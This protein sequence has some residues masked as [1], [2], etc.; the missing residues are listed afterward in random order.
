MD[1]SPHERDLSQ[2]T[3]CPKLCRFCCPTA[4]VE[5]KETVTPW[6]KMTLCEMFRLGRLRS[7][8]EIGEVFFHCFTCLHCRTHCRHGVDVPSALI[9]GRAGILESG[10]G[11]SEVS[12]V[13]AR[14]EASGNPWGEDL[15]ARLRDEVP[16]EFFVSE[17][18][19]VLF[20]G[21]QAILLK[22]GFLRTVF[23]LFSHLEV[24]YVAAFD[25][26]DLCCGAPLWQAGDLRRFGRH[27]E[28]LRARLS[29]YR[30]IL[31]P[32]PTCV[33]VLRARFS[34][35]GFPIGGQV[36]HLVEFLAPL[37]ENRPP[38]RKIRGAH[39]FHDP[40]YLGRF[41][42]N[43]E[44][45]RTLLSKVL[46]DPLRE[47]VWAKAD[48]SCCGGGGLMP[49][50]LPEIAKG[51]AALRMEQLSHTGAKRVV[52]ACPGCARMLGGVSKGLP[53]TDLVSVLER[54]YRPFR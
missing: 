16:G 31:C 26:E 6:G 48:A 2:C 9:Q 41:L 1:L 22:G 5:H 30:K 32:C 14:F 54:A 24:D 37:L 17:A 13:I 46:R 19:A 12:A 23:R 11:P 51:Q 7:G 15:R 33:Q 27:V 47:S 29:G 49:L 28:K 10:R 38:L 52:T 44:P 36:L 45:P 50:V 18:Q 42:E 4:E 43:T 53:V 21:C 34:E 35:L 40:C 25:G 8:A 20:G 39:V 3:Y